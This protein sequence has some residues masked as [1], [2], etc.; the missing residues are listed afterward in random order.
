MRADAVIP[1]VSGVVLVMN[2]EGA[3]VQKSVNVSEHSATCFTS[4]HVDFF[5]FL[6]FF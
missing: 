4:S 5:F 1:G 6:L 3:Q 2:P